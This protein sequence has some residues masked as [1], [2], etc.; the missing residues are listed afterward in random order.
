MTWCGSV[1]ISAGGEAASRRGKRGNNT[2]WTNTNLTGDDGCG[3]TVK[4]NN[5]GG[6]SFDG[7]VLWLERG[8]MET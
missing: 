3:T 1:T 8:K 5:G 4:V 6:W 2:S 7:V